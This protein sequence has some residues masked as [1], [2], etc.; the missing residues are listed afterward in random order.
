M[1]QTLGKRKRSAS[2][3]SLTARESTP[4]TSDNLALLDAATPAQ[5]KQKEQGS[6]R[7]ETESVQTAMSVDSSSRLRYCNIRIDR[8][9]EEYWP[10]CLKDVI[11]TLLT[12]RSGPPSPSASHVVAAQREAALGSEG[13]GVQL[14][15]EWL[16][17]PHYLRTIEYR[18]QYPLLQICSPAVLHKAY[19]PLV[20]STIEPSVAAVLKLSPEEAR[21]DTLVG[22]AMREVVADGRQLRI[23]PALS[24]SQEATA[25]SSRLCK[26]ME[27]PFLSVQWKSQRKGGNHHQARCQGARDGATIVSYNYHLST[28]AKLETTVEDTCH[29]SA[30]C[31]MDSL[32]FYVHWRHQA[33]N[34]LVTFEMD[35]VLFCRLRDY[36]QV[37][38]ARHFVRNLLDYAMEKRLP[39]ARRV[40]DELQGSKVPLPKPSASLAGRS[41]APAPT[42]SSMV[43]NSEPA[44]PQSLQGT[45]RPRLDNSQR[46]EEEVVV[47]DVQLP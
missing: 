46:E 37:V 44:S 30:T 17:L 25:T 38:K 34:G 26:D 8:A 31:D 22:F 11:S 32:A 21:P 7:E 10:R 15:Q 29:F 16:F 41:F 4:L 23:E 28:I 35:E 6:S 27:C 45:K 14:L 2:E 1:P 33:D 36:N 40:L 18:Q 5:K 20:N 12:P 9:G 43:S 3:T 24:E 47:V 42:P 13:N 19:L 39:R